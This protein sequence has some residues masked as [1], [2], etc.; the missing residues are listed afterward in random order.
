MYHC[1]PNTNIWTQR[2]N[3]DFEE[4]L[5]ERFEKMDLSD[6][7]A[8]HVTTRRGRADMLHVFSTKMIQNGF[9]N[10]LDT[11]LHV[12]ACEN[13][14]FDTSSGRPVFRPLTPQDYVLTTASFVYD[15]VKEQGM[16]GELEEFLA[17][18]LPVPEERRVVLNF[19]AN[20]LS[21][22]R[23]E[24][25]F[26]LLTDRRSGN[27]G[28]TSLMTLFR[29]FFGAYTKVVSTKFVCRGPLDHGRDTH[30]GGL[31]PMKGKRLLI[32]EE[33]KNYMTLDDAFFKRIVG[34]VDTVIEGRHC[35]SSAQFS[36]VWQAGVVLVANEG[37]VP[38][39]DAGD[40]AFA[41][42]MIVVPMRSK[43]IDGVVEADCDEEYTYPLDPDM[44]ERFLKWLP[45]LADILV[46]HYDRRGLSNIPRE[47][48]EWHRRIAVADNPCADWLDKHVRVTGNKNDFLIAEDLKRASG[49]GGSVAEYARMVKS[50]FKDDTRVR[51]IDHSVI[52]ELGGQ[53]RYI[54]RGV[55]MVN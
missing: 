9:V 4:L 49:A 50:Y 7:D 26:L 15:P 12:F 36:F 24:K 42:R 10:R 8:K 17:R 2:H 22:V 53:A 44:K 40:A 54:I 38:M 27:N 41:Q 51:V 18:V 16:R 32:S 37:D 48:M 45:A 14:A 25:K 19:F 43:F 3:G 30:D 20:L 55:E 23:S 34:G 5:V 13:G 47:M 29:S 21:G 46:E 39:F 11:N 33:L 31:E 6:K 52:K 28:K 1:D 35:G